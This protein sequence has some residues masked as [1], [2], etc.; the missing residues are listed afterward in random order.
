[1]GGGEKGRTVVSAARYP[2]PMLT[3]NID[4]LEPRGV[5]VVDRVIPHG[6]S[7]PVAPPACSSG[8]VD[9]A[10]LGSV[11]LRRRALAEWERSRTPLVHIVYCAPLPCAPEPATKRHAAKRHAQ[12]GNDDGERVRGEK[13]GCACEVCRVSVYYVPLS[14]LR[15]DDR[16]RLERL[17]ES[18]QSPTTTTTT[19]TTETAI[20]DACG[21]FEDGVHRPEDAR[22]R[23]LPRKSCRPSKVGDRNDENCHGS[24]NANPE[25]DADSKAGIGGDAREEAAWRWWKGSTT[26]ARFRPYGFRPWEVG[27]VSANVYR[28]Y[29]FAG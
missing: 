10:R 4:D 23:A 28:A 29:F 20:S 25:P 21:G 9:D 6:V 16:L 8:R 14:E 11:L 5:V 2:P 13:R 26:Q 7:R 22:S 1:M 12:D 24:R 17:A 19:T 15:T 18:G 27:P 3:C